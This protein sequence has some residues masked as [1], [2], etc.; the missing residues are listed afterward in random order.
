[1]SAVLSDCV[2]QIKAVPDWTVWVG[3][4]GGAVLT[5][6]QQISVLGSGEKQKG[7]RCVSF[8]VY[9]LCVYLCVLPVETPL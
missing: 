4:A 1:M 2:D 8:H 9:M 5:N 3:P 6:L 7:F